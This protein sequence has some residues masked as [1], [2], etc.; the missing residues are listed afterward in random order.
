MPEQLSYC[1]ALVRA[2]DHDRFLTALFAAEPAREDLFALYAFNL[3]IARIR[4]MA[5]EPL[6]G[7]IRLQWWR[8]G[9][10]AIHEGQ[11]VRAHPVLQALNAA[12][13]RSALPRAPFDALIDAHARDFETAP[14]ATLREL[15]SYCDATSVGLMRLA[16]GVAGAGAAC[17]A[18][19]RH[20]GIAWALTGLLRSVGFHAA[21]GQIFLPGDKMHAEGLTQESILNCRNGPE[22]RRIM[23]ALAGIADGHL[24]AARRLLPAPSRQ[25]M[26]ALLPATL[27]QSYLTQI[28]RP[29]HDPFRMAEPVPAFR[30]QTRLLMAMLLRRL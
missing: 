3:E 16:L 28:R 20:A 8:E 7:E 21:R 22:L 29:D 27:A 5:S 6:L 25:I 11:P 15:E 2:G 9:L 1:G 10:E 19:A 17:D 18:M 26:P 13:K 30:R 14:P 24:T 23:M 4:A 12:I